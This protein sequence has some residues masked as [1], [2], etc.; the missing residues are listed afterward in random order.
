MPNPTPRDYQQRSLLPYKNLNL[1]M[2][3]PDTKATQK[4]IKLRLNAQLLPDIG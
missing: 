1:V 3:S 4:E 2:Y